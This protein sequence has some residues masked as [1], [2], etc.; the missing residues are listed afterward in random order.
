MH[1][2][3]NEQVMITR[4]RTGFMGTIQPEKEK[5]NNEY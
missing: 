5:T 1:Y 4:T 2:C 3:L